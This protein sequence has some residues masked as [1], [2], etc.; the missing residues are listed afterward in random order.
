MRSIELWN[1]VLF[2]CVFWGAFSCRNTHENIL[3]KGELANLETPLIIVTHIRADSLV[4]DSIYAKKGKFS[5]KNTIDTLTVFTFYLND[6]RT[7]SMVFANKDDKIELKGDALLPDLVEVR[8]SEIN[9]DLS[10]FKKQNHAL[11]L[12]RTELLSTRQNNNDNTNNNSFS[13][14]SEYLSKKNSIN[15]ELI[16][17]AENYIKENPTKIAS[18]ILINDFLKNSR[19]PD[20]FNRSLDYLQGAALQFPLTKSLKTYNLRLRRSV[21]G[22]YSPHFTLLDIL[23]DTVRSKDYEG[24]FLVI[25]FLSCAGKK[26]RE[27]VRLLKLAYKGIDKK[28]TD[29]LTL[30]IDTDLYPI[31][32]VV[33]DSIEWTVVPEKKGWGADI[34]EAYNIEYVPQNI[35]ISPKGVILHR[36]IPAR[37]IAAAIEAENEK[38]K[39]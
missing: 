10:K 19:N 4:V 34:V 27:N 14:E 28:N 29:F 30:Y 5:Y 3:I 37:E 31:K 7:S 39:K 15:H 25:S 35:L 11:L 23:N 18:V 26:S 6:Y 16:L 38:E 22:A 1:I 20:A 36:D 9:D 21:E 12:E 2:I 13:S 32:N 8:G 17:N 33:Q 24:R